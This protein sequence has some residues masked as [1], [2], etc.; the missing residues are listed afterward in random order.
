MCA[1]LLL[2]IYSLPFSDVPPDPYLLNLVFTSYAVPFSLFMIFLFPLSY[3]YLFTSYNYVQVLLTVSFFCHTVFCS[4]GLPIRVYVYILVP[5]I[6]LF[7]FLFKLF[8][9]R[10]LLQKP[11]FN[12]FSS[13]FEIASLIIML[14]F[15][16]LFLFP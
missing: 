3:M 1:C 9:F 8:Y 13:C 14:L 2:L 11:I 7:L 15:F 16:S 6:Y 4:V 10:S 12:V 5:L